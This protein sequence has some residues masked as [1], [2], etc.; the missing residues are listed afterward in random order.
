MADVMDWGIDLNA[1]LPGDVSDAKKMQAPGDMPWWEQ[2]IKTGVTKLIDNAVQTH[3]QVQGNTDPG[4]FAG[5]NGRTYS[6]EEAKRGQGQPMQGNPDAVTVAANKPSEGFSKWGWLAVAGM[7][8][9]L[10]VD[11]R[12]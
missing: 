7:G 12:R 10:F 9:A 1:M 3:T 2:A 4:S 6:S 11:M 8:I 5:Q